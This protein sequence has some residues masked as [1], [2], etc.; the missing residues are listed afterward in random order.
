[1]D[2]LTQGMLGAALTLSVSKREHLRAAAVLG[3]LS[4]MA[5]DLDVLIRSSQDPLLFLEYHR[6]FT[7]SL[8]FIPFGSLLCALVFYF[9]FSK[10][11]DLS[12]QRT[13]FYCAL[14]YGTHGVLD[15]CTSYGT[16]LFWP[17]SDERVAFNIIS[18]I[19]PVF[20]LPLLVLVIFAFW[21][22]RSKPALV[23]MSWTSVYLIIG[24]IQKDR[25]ETAGLELAKERQHTPVVLEVKPTL[26]NLL[27]W[28]VVYEV[29]QTYFVDAIRVGVN[30]KAYSG[31]SI[32]K[33]DVA[34]D[35]QWVVQDS[36]QMIDVERFSRFSN[37]YLALDPDNQH[38]IIDVRYSM[39]PNQIDALWSIELSQSANISDHVKYLVDR[40][41]TPASIKT[42]TR[43]L[44]GRD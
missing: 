12:F 40:E 7:H 38:R 3:G 4:G 13:W 28:K 41:S 26:A 37:G 44:L 30:T 31:D 32:A 17:I 23:A 20:T 29:N 27:V 11:C 19:D 18:V 34:T 5:P 9:I 42:F 21:Q 15:T 8:L 43:M 24:G 25:A 10:R 6:Q 36:Q 39:V 1:M 2:P 14:G 22:Y 35:L 33:L 16:Q